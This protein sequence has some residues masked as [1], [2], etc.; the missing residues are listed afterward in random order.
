[1]MADRLNFIIKMQLKQMP[2]IVNVWR[3]CLSL[4]LPPYNVLKVR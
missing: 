2:K 4:N 1:M 3:S